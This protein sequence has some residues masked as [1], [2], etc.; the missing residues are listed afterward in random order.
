MVALLLINE[1][2]SK[3]HFCHV[4]VVN[5]QICFCVF[6]LFSVK[7]TVTSLHVAQALVNKGMDKG[8]DTH[9]ESVV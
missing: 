1:R 6:F 4:S 5:T 8:K 7:I 2:S 9:P 3:V